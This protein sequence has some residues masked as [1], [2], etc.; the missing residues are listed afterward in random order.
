MKNRFQTPALLL[1]FLTFFTYNCKPESLNN[2]CDVKSDSFFSNLI[3][4][5]VTTAESYHC[6]YNLVN[7][8]PFGYK[9]SNY[10]L[11]LNF[12][13]SIIPRH[14]KNSSYSIQG[15]LPA[16]LSFDGATGEI[17]GTATAITP[18]TNL[19][20]TKSS[21]G[22]GIVTITLQV[23]DT[24]ATM[25]YGQYGFYHCANNYNDGACAP[26]G[27][28]TNQNLS[29]PYGVVADS[30]GGVYVSGVN[31]IQYY[32]PNTISSTKVYGQFGVFACDTANVL[33]AGSCSVA[34]VNA[35]SLNSIRGLALDSN[36]NLYG[37][38]TAN[39]RVLF[40]PKESFTA[41]NVYGQA[42]FVT[43]ISGP[44][45]E[46]TMNT[47][48]GVAQNS[49]GIYVSE[50]AN[51]RILF[52][53]HG[54]TK[55]SRLYGQSNFTSNTPSV[56][57]IK[58]SSPYGMSLDSEGGL[59]VADSGNSRVLYFPSGST[60]ATRV[61]GQSDFDTSGGG[62]ASPTTLTG[63]TR[64]A[65]DQSD[66]LFVA[67]TTNNRVVMYP[68]TT[69]TAGI[70]AVAVFGQFNNLNCGAPNNDGVCGGPIVGPKSLSSPTGLF[71]NQ[72]GQLY[73]AD[74]QNN[75]VLV[76]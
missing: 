33:S 16:G 29:S 30:S 38:D 3:F 14:P 50:S 71:F 32:P 54:S 62:A 68:R 74:R 67:D 56:S 52:F 57:N 5:A 9:Y 21:P 65:L 13:V 61:Y 49:E 51:H 58:M 17:R 64:V 7:I 70:A 55:P 37:V 36:E 47:P 23:V 35:N 46:S 24:S 39:H 20:I 28:V 48:L 2:Q 18:A 69:Q 6:G 15:V 75:R 19:T 25:V 8:P 1:L 59:Y 4:Q 76:Y 22:F 42:G 43:A 72:S 27:P 40:Y 60:T 53:P 12:P 11:Y 26:G 34:T 41:T 31:R 45:S 63:P 10:R 66:K 44:V 73:I